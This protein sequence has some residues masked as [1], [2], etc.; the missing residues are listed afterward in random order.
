MKFEQESNSEV[1]YFNLLWVFFLLKVYFS[2]KKKKKKRKKKE[3]TT[4][5][6]HGKTARKDVGLTKVTKRRTGDRIMH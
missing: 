5:N 4:K 2:Q 3:T 6:Q 1:M